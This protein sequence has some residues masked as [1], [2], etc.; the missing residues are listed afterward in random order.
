[1]PEPMAI[2]QNGRRLLWPPIC[3]EQKGLWRRLVMAWLLMLALSPMRLDKSMRRDPGGAE[4][5]K[6]TPEYTLS[7]ASFGPVSLCSTWKKQRGDRENRRHVLPCRGITNPLQVKGLRL[8]D[9][10]PR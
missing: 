7:T 2:V 1:M 3:A 4:L 9:H 6:P 10:V 8:D 5:P